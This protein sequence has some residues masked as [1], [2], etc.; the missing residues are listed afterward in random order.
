MSRN[1]AILE[2]GV[3]CY[4]VIVVLDCYVVPKTAV[5]EVAGLTGDGYIVVRTVIMIF[6]INVQFDSRA[7]SVLNVIDV[8]E[9]MSCALLENI[10][11]G[12]QSKIDRII[13]VSIE[14]TCPVVIKS[15]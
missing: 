3:R 4:E 10:A 5:A 15:R 6:V 12:R 7:G 14:T 8:V 2:V 1:T 9:Y 13:Q 11:T